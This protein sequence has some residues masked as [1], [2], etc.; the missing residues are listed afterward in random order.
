MTQTNFKRGAPLTLGEL[1][2]L[3][4]G[5]LVW[6]KMV[7]YDPFVRSGRVVMHDGPSDIHRDSDGESWTLYDAGG[8]FW[9]DSSLPEDTICHDLFDEGE[10]R[11]WK[12]KECPI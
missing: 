8:G 6:A 10:T 3:P 9:M 12:V 7:T 2:R 11:L 4:D 1:K 5:A